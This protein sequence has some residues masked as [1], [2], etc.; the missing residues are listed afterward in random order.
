MANGIIRARK[1]NQ[2]LYQ[3]AMFLDYCLIRF[4]TH[5]PF[6]SLLDIEFV[7]KRI[8][9]AISALCQK[10]QN[11]GH[12]TNYYATFPPKVMTSFRI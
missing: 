5:L 1:Q 2:I 12:I 11:T 4:S 9:D 10:Y 6:P 8:N 3:Y 7:I